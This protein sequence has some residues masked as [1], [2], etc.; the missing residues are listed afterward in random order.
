MIL[1]T[2]CLSKQW[3]WE[4]VSNLQKLGIILLNSVIFIYFLVIFSQQSWMAIVDDDAVQ[5]KGKSVYH[6]RDI[7]ATWQ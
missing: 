1:S 5:E 7:Q 2:A 6:T 3:A 4:K